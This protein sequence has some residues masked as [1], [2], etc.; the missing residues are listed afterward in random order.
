MLEVKVGKMEQSPILT[1]QGRFDG[2]GSSIFDAAVAQIAALPEG[3]ILLDM[4]D[5]DFLSSAGLRSLILLRK[6]VARSKG[7][8]WLIAMQPAVQQVFA[9]AG[10][11]AHFDV[12]A[13][14]SEAATRLQADATS[15]A[16]ESVVSLLGRDHKMTPVQNAT[17]VLEHLPAADKL[18]CLALDELG[19][20]LG[21][22][23]LGNTLA[24]ANE[25]VGSFL[26]TGHMVSVRPTAQQDIPPDFI[27]TSQPEDLPVY[28]AEAW[29]LTGTPS[30]VV[31]SDQGVSDLKELT[32]TFPELLRNAVGQQ[33]P[34]TAWILA[35]TDPN[36]ESSNGWVVV[37]F[38]GSDGTSQMEAI[39]IDQLHLTTDSIEPQDFLKTALQAESLSGA[40]APRKGLSVGRYRAWLYAPA[41]QPAAGRRCNV[42]FEDVEDPHEE[43]DWIARRIYADA[44]D[45]R[46]R[47]L[48]GGFSAATF[49]VESVDNEGRRLLPTVLKLADV[50][51]SERED[52][53]YDLYVSKY[54]L[55][56]SAVRMGRCARNG[57]VG[58]RYNF[59]G[60]TG[61]ESRLRWI[62]EDLVKRPIEE[63][64]P[65]FIELFQKILAPWY[66]QT[67][68]CA[69]R[70]YH[71]H[72][73]RALFTGLC[74]EVF[75]VLGISVDQPF[76]HCPALGRDLP[77]PYFLLEH[78]YP[79][80]AD[81]EWDGFSSIVHGDLNLN[82]VLL[83][84]KENIYVIDFSETH[85]GDFCSDFSRMEP[86]V[87]LQMTRL[88][89]ENDLTLLLE[90]LQ[91]SINPETF[92]D[93]PYN[94]A[95][96]DPFMPKAHALVRIL[97][98][99]VSRL[100]GDR[101]YI[102][103]YLLG[104]LRWS[105]PIIVFRQLPLLYKQAS[106]YASALIAE[107]LLEA[108]PEAG[109]YFD[110]SRD[111]SNDNHTSGISPRT[112]LQ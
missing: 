72:D 89:G 100:A 35:A 110:P 79:A 90:Y 87:L 106:F 30:A 36:K 49:Y 47:K 32:D 61:P 88:S 104:L 28:V 8:V 57:W 9:M 71:E 13:S 37:G 53:A 40:F 60:I 107:A 95:G 52:R 33:P 24:Q 39:S 4:K 18:T 48:E 75:P 84:E 7:R 91:R 58:L 68:P 96:D 93:P 27:V 103:P 67:R 22:A 55:N 82:N 73:P 16:Q 108:D 50:A 81:A 45:I 98:S 15:R 94:Y 12:V 77:N 83:D 109:S 46:L 29:R 31:V 102:V 112:L 56:N 20:A 92:F 63:T 69:V 42:V 25:A 26:S 19:I 10:L 86:L 65:L 105:L 17:S 59:V 23:G 74:A 44:Y 38:Q 78:V 111:V 97:R 51:F 76:I 1:M 99:E 70:P 64:E 34:C 43:W 3:P 41:V 54:I 62:G 85:I 101:P 66:G 2:M 11:L 6:S 14:C 21:R 80:R 5:V